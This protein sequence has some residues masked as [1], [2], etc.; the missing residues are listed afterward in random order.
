MLTARVGLIDEGAST[1]SQLGRGVAAA[2]VFSPLPV[3][4][5]SVGLGSTGLDVTVPSI[6]FSSTT[7]P[8]V[9]SISFP[10][11][12]LHVTVARAQMISAARVSVAVPVA[13]FKQLT[14]S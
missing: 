4:L 11:R 12:P 9:V 2:L 5:T 8:I 10:L 7:L 3:S 13:N 6:P 14:F 1:G